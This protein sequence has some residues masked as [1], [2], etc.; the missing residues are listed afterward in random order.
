MHNLFVYGTL[1]Y[2]EVLGRVVRGRYRRSTGV[3]KGYKRRRI[4]GEEYPG[5]V[6]DPN[7]TVEGI[8]WL[9]VNAEDIS[10]LDDFEGDEYERVPAVVWDQSRHIMQVQVYRIRKTHLHILDDADWNR[11]EFEQHGLARFHNAAVGFD[12]RTSEAP[13]HGSV[14]F[15]E[16]HVTPQ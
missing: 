5:L 2:E 1:M 3:L 14:S 6:G 11:E 7:S 13:S 16:G 10:R 8:V 9:G 4:R 12:P 15:R